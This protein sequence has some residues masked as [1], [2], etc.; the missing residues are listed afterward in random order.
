ML[1][2]LSQAVYLLNAPLA[3]AARLAGALQAKAEQDPSILKGGAGEPA[4]AASGQPRTPQR[5]RPRPAPSRPRPQRAEP[6]T[7]PEDAPVRGHHHRGH[8]KHRG[9]T[10]PPCGDGRSTTERNATMAKLSTD[11]LLD[12]FKEMTLLELSEFVKQ[13]EETFGVTAAAPVAVAAAPPPAAPAP[14][15]KRPPS[16]TSSTSSS[17]PPARRRSTSSRRSAP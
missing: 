8:T 9:L 6:R 12:A 3:Q 4:A 16:R 2:S 1:A 17:R 14:L 13:F 15:P 11:E 5:R 7:L 10:I